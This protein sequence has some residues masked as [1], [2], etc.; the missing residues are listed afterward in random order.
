M[1]RDEERQRL[2]QENTALYDALQKKDE[3][4]GQLLK[5]NQD[6]REGLKHAI[7]AIKSQQERN[8]ILEGEIEYLQERVK[9]LEKQ[10]AR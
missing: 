6:L 5:A 4:L 8:K 9:T 2:R 7:T 1:T 10:Q 3:E